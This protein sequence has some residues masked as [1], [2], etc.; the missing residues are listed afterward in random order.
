MGANTDSTGLATDLIGV[1]FSDRFEEVVI[2]IL[3]LVVMLLSID[4]QFKTSAT[5]LANLFFN[6]C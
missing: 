5:Q 2:F 3:R 4:L 6:S 1:W